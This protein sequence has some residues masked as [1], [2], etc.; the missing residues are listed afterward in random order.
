LRRVVRRPLV[1][2][3]AN[4]LK[5]ELFSLWLGVRIPSSRDL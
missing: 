4:G 5:V 1:G 3:A 2:A